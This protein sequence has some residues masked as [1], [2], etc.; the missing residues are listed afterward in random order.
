LSE[1][2]GA[3][4]LA[5]QARVITAKEFLTLVK[6]TIAL[7]KK[8]QRSAGSI[9]VDGR[10]VHLPHSGNTIIVGDLHGDLKGLMHILKD[11][12]FLTKLRKGENVHLIFLGDYGDRG[13][14]SPEVYYVIL[15]LKETFPEKVI[16]MRGNHEGPED[17][18]PFPHDLPDRLKQKYGEKSG[19]KTYAELRK[20]FNYL[21]SAVLIDDRAVLI[22]GGVPSEA[23]SAEDLAYAHTKHPRESHLEEM[24]WSDPRE[25]MTGTRSSP[26]GAGKLFGADVTERFLR[27]LNVKVLIRGHEPNQKGFKIN[28]NG[29]V[30]TLFST[31]LPPYR[32]KRSAYLQINF[33]KT[34]KNAQQLTKYIKQFG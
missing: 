11:S 13:P 28:H 15:K 12:G 7:L 3:R 32:N 16:L 22:H 14:A 18:L 9:R 5:N 4:D 20:L 27:L 31:N 23:M 19:A 21:Y 8:E 1:N 6:R 24:L 10:L 2:L 17:L 26:R 33:S 25:K 30:L 34:I 29:K